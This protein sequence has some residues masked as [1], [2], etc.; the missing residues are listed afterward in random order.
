[1]P[2]PG[3]SRDTATTFIV[4]AVARPHRLA[5]ALSPGPAGRGQDT[6]GLEVPAVKNG[7]RV[8]GGARVQ[9]DGPD[10]HEATVAPSGDGPRGALLATAY[11]FVRYLTAEAASTGCRGPRRAT[12]RAICPDGHWVGRGDPAGGT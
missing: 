9:P 8:V 12:Q 10:S 3:G 2:G 7:V 1:M 11:L 5:D 6:R 4:T